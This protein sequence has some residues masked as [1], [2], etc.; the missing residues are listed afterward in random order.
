VKAG[1]REVI[2]SQAESVML[3]EEKIGNVPYF[4]YLGANLTCDGKDEKEIEAR[5]RKAKPAFGAHKSIWNDKKLPLELK[6]R[7]YNTYFRRRTKPQRTDMKIST[8][9]P[10]LSLAYFTTIRN[11]RRIGTI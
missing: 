8:Y 2:I 11:L 7:L 9:T 3:D 10:F 4:K 5:I 1:K 6:L